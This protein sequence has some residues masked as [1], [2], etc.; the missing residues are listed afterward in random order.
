MVLDFSRIGTPDTALGIDSQ[1]VGLSFL[2][3]GKKKGR[4][5]GKRRRGKE[6]CQVTV[7]LNKSRVGCIAN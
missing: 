2:S 5:E 4:Q 1:S 7:G 3:R 6:G